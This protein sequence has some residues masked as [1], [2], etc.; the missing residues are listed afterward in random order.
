MGAGAAN[1][2]EVAGESLLSTGVDP[3]DA[4]VEGLAAG[5]YYVLSG[6]PGAG[7]SSAALHFAGAG[8]DQGESVAILT[9]DDPADLLVQA[10]FLGY[11]FQ[12]PADED[13][14]QI[15]RYRLDFHRNYSR[16]AEPERVFEEL[17]SL[18][19]DNIPRRFIIDSVLPLLEGGLAAEESVDA[20]ARF[21]EEIPCTTYLT[22]P[23]DLNESYYRR[24]YNRVTAGSAG[25]FHFE[26]TGGATRRM[27]I[28]KLRQKMNSSE[29]IDFVIRPGAGI[30]EDLQLRSHD[31]LPEELRRR[32]V[33]LSQ[34]SQFPEEWLPALNHAFDIVSHASIEKAFGDLASA[35][36]GALLIAMD[37]MEPEPALRLTRELRK[38]GNGAPILFVSPMKGLR[39]Q[40]RAKGLRAGGDD[41][42]T[43]VL[44]PE[45]LLARIDNARVRGHRRIASASVAA[46][47]P[48]EQ[49]VDDDGNALIMSA[50]H[51]RGVLRD[52]VEK[53]EHAFFALVVLGAGQLEVAEAWSVLQRRLRVTD[54]DLVAQMENGQFALYLHDVNRRQVRDLI[55]RLIEENPAVA[56]L[57][58]TTFLCHPADSDAVGAWLAGDPLADVDPEHA[59]NGTGSG[60]GKAVGDGAG[61]VGGGPLASN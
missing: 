27:T 56:D 8:L 57:A 25:I 16:S 42:L 13:R 58:S 20:F 52:H 3:F 59:G 40:T 30:V 2:P 32:I 24:I 10:N 9:Q 34:G 55:T 48:C 61:V 12:D 53:A 7:K 54:G 39:G 29:P 18:L 51:F 17:K 6:A 23:G 46:E 5:R 45:E 43:D 21:L 1:D 31:D 35:T 47:P 11:D 14:L 49:P 26:S 50:D 37:P 38:A 33:L 44:S 15:L 28:R 4:R 41:F 22:V 60:A 36:Y 19:W